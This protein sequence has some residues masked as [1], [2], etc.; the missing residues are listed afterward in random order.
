VLI[1]LDTVADMN[2]RVQLI[3]LGQDTSDAMGSCC[4]A[5][6]I[7]DICQRLLHPSVPLSDAAALKLRQQRGTANATAPS[8]GTL[9]RSLPV[10]LLYDDAGLDQFNRITQVCDICSNC[11]HISKCLVSVE[12]TGNTVYVTSASGSLPQRARRTL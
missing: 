3:T 2:G 12:A 8:G 1:V 9:L 6:L 5:Q 4:S 7:Q 11:N 10:E